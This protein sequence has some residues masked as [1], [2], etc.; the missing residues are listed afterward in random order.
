MW[1]QRRLVPEPPVA[2]QRA[3]DA[4]SF[5][6]PDEILKAVKGELEGKTLLQIKELKIM[7]ANLC[8]SQALAH[9]HA[10]DVADHLVTLTD[11]A[12]LPVVMTVMNA[13]Q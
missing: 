11:I 6:K 2:P 4:I 10:A 3:S 13:C 9:R 1:T 7:I 8:R 5:N 12:S